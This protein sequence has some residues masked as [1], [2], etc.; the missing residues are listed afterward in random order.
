[1]DNS[2]KKKTNKNFLWRIVDE[3]KPGFLSNSLKL[4]EMQVLY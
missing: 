3:T 2:K 4:I 1:M